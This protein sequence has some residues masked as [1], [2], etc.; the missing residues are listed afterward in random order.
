MSQSVA[1][2]LI[3]YFGEKIFLLSAK[4]IQTDFWVIFQLALDR[5]RRKEFIFCDRPATLRPLFTEV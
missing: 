3:L 4:I 1:G 2:R 5:Y